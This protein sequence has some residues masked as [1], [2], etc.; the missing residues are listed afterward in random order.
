[1]MK[2]RLCICI[3]LIM[4]CMSCVTHKAV[5][6]EKE[7]IHDTLIVHRDSFVYRALLDS[8]WEHE[9]IVIETKHDTINNVDTVFV[10]TTKLKNHIIQKT[11][12]V[13]KKQFVRYTKK[14]DK[15]K[16]S[17]TSSNKIS[18]PWWLVIVLLV[19]GI[20]ILTINKD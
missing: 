7:I 4:M 9:S 14:C 11:D 5:E 16:V 19:G 20:T 17:K 18:F 12:T 2:G 3:I 6:K 15:N 13:Y 1:M 8:V 10:T